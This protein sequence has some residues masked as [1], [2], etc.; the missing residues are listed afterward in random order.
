MTKA[1][2]KL[3]IKCRRLNKIRKMTKNQVDIENHRNVRREVK[4]A[5]EKAKVYLMRIWPENFKII[6]HLINVLETS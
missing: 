1:I 4:L 6:K 2:R 5:W 3:I